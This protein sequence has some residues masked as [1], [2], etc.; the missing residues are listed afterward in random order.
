MGNAIPVNTIN[1]DTVS[2]TVTQN[3]LASNLNYPYQINGTVG[4]FINPGYF[5]YGGGDIRGVHV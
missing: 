1:D 3:V 5:V 4:D 2:Y